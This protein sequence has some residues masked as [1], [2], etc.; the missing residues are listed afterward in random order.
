MSKDSLQL[1]GAVRPS[2]DFESINREQAGPTITPTRTDED[3]QNS[4]ISCSTPTGSF[5]DDD[6]V[7]SDQIMDDV[8]LDLDGQSI[9]TS[10]DTSMISNL[11]DMNFDDIFTNVS[12][13][14]SPEDALKSA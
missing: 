11:D 5:A 3:S 2:T 9:D 4:T 1:S 14:S 13:G 12:F 6:F 10:L 7:V 8:T